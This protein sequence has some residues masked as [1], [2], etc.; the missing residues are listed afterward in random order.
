MK[1]FKLLSLTAILSITS[2]AYAAEPKKGGEYNGN[3]DIIFGEQMPDFGLKSL[4]P[5]KLEVGLKL[6]NKSIVLNV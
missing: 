6:E 4:V 3:Q 1:T 5:G 2:M